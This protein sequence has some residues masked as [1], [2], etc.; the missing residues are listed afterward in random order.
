M[1][2]MRGANRAA[3]RVGWGLLPLLVWLPATARSA[4]CR[5]WTCTN[6]LF[7]IAPTKQT[8][9]MEQA[10]M[11]P[12][13]N[14]DCV[15]A[16]LQDPVD[17]LC[18]C[19]T[20]GRVPVWILPWLV[21][22]YAFIVAFFVLVIKW[23][24]AKPKAEYM[25]LR[26]S[27]GM[28][29]A[30]LQEPNEPL[31]SKT[32]SWMRKSNHEIL[33]EHGLDA[34]IYLLHCEQCCKYWMA[35]F[36]AIG[37]LL[38]YFYSVHGDF[39][40]GWNMFAWS[41]ANL[42]PTNGL[43]WLPALAQFW[44]AGTTLLFA[45]SKQKAMDAYKHRAE[46]AGGRHTSLNTVWIQGL[47]STA[48]EQDLMRWF[49]RNYGDRLERDG[50]GAP[51]AK[52]VWDVNALG[53]NV[54][55]QRKYI[56]QINRLSKTKPQMTPKQQRAAD[57]RITKLLHKVDTLRVWEKPLR[58]RGKRPAGSAFVTFSDEAHCLSFRRAMLY[59]CQDHDSAEGVALGVPNWHTERA[60]RPADIY[61][62]NFGL[63]PNEQLANHANVMFFTLVLFGTFVLF[64]LAIM[65]T[66]GFLYFELLYRVYP[67]ES[68][69]MTHRSQY[70]AVGPY[71]WYGF[72]GVCAVIFLA[73]EEE[74]SPLV[75]F[76]VKF[77][78]PLTKSHKQS[79]YLH[80]I[81]FFY[82]I[83]H[84][85]LTT[86]LFGR[87]VLW[88]EVA[89]IPVEGVEGI[90]T[91]SGRL[92][93]YVETVGAFHQNRLFLTSCVIDMLHVMEGASFF[94]RKANALT[95]E[96]ESTFQG[97]EDLED[98]EDD[99]HTVADNRFLNCKFDYTRNYGESI[100]V[101]ASISVYA[102]M[103]PTIMFFGSLYFL[104]K[105]FVDKYQICNQYSRPQVQYGRRARTT[106]IVILMSQ[107]M[108][109]YFN[110]FYF[111][112]LAP[113]GWN[114]VGL[115]CLLS[116]LGFT[117]LSGL[118]MYQPE[119]LKVFK[120]STWVAEEAKSK[121]SGATA[122]ASPREGWHEQ[123][124]E[125]KD[126][127]LIRN[128]YNPPAPDS[129][130]VGVRLTSQLFSPRLSQTG[131]GL[132]DDQ[133]ASDSTTVTNA[134]AGPLPLIARTAATEATVHHQPALQRSSVHS[135]GWRNDAPF[136]HTARTPVGSQ[137]T[138]VQPSATSVTWANEQ[139]IGQ[140]PAAPA[141]TLSYSPFSER[142]GGGQR[143]PS[144]QASASNVI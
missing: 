135:P 61:W 88:L 131:R 27:Q 11:Y 127:D 44:F 121:D 85:L 120:S 35:Q 66:I 26:R 102:V 91:R 96:Q 107:L 108:A 18:G 8:V 63:D 13:A 5:E 14:E 70:D 142:V 41:Y 79:V 80:N 69:Y 54:R 60:P 32:S 77:E 67:K 132:N 29:D 25:R 140:T 21:V 82:V 52:M 128:I 124:S 93:L 31:T 86:V 144:Q 119:S 114:G 7:R 28:T 81:F 17:C 22:V 75:K 97:A 48:T 89:D 38:C 87:L 125:G 30:E 98:E 40:L 117:T 42:A 62:E 4:M 112:V 16:G 118:Y 116:A 43:K 113:D 123:G 92:Q 72:G 95:A 101:M 129:L 10:Y 126:L 36:C 1:V 115:V 23:L 76:L 2:T 137:G 103:H 139:P 9:S 106:T 39:E 57:G 37:A 122:A 111:L 143:G 47:A 78:S 133:E 64:G 84:V 65:W 24:R 53:H 34:A 71:L 99:V 46:K 100:A 104:I 59:Q 33:H 19:T 73:L 51:R 20:P 105:H 94:T 138:N 45:K 15:A 83:Y 110:S 130:H 141:R 134:L 136:N 6:P 58:Q 55:L 90:T 109:Q 68:M 3:T 50:R 56:K 49:E 12:A 74:M